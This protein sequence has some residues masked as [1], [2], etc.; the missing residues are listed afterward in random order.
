[1][2]YWVNLKNIESPDILMEIQVLAWEGDNNVS[3]V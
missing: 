1:V 3:P 2:K